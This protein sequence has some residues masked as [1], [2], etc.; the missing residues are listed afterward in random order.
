VPDH[1]QR[2][3][4]LAELVVGFGA[5]VQPGQVVAISTA[6][7]MESI[8]RELA[9]AAYARG[10][11]WVDVLTWDLWVK[12]ARIEL[13]PEQSLD[14]VPPWLIDRLEWLSDERGARISLSG[15][16]QPQALRGVDP[17]RAGRDL[18]PYLPNTGKVVNAGTMNWC[19]APA[20]TAGWAQLVY[21]DLD[22][23]EALEELWA[24][25]WRMCRLDADDP[26]AAWQARGAELVGVG[27]RLDAARFDAVR[28][29]GP[30]TDLTV[31]LL[32]SS[33]WAGGG[34]ETAWGLRF[35]P[36][37]PTEEVFTTPDPQR[38]DG[39]VTATRPL[40]LH[41]SILE[42]IRV[43]FEAGRAIRIDA[44]T[45]AEVLRAAA[46]KDAGAC[47]LGELALVDDSGRVGPLG[48]VF[49]DTLIDENAA[50][51][52]ALGNGYKKCVSD[53]VDADRVNQ[54]TIH[55]DFMIGSPQLNV[56]GITHAG[57]HVAVLREGRWQL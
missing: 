24:A 30:G 15:P 34:D 45:H 8:S 5:N 20:P 42:G 37:I 53:P 10:A 41:G 48:R 7:G 39:T 21:A 55:I 50:S 12:R 6:T 49:Y 18:L 36:N 46:A 28:L 23:D 43:E 31:G 16:S 14:F 2:T 54:S 9:R 33:R 57:E 26:A 32:P 11:R 19:V 25:V 3:R 13:A 44:D 40:E 17:A 27:S 1:A 56:D 35:L 4:S 51:H 38:V 52:I 29:H 47:R 22:P